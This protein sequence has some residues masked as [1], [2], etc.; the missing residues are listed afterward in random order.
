MK[1]AQERAKSREEGWDSTRD[2]T[3]IKEYNALF[4][5]N[6]RHFFE[7]PSVQAHLL[8]TGQVFGSVETQYPKHIDRNGRVIDFQKQ[9]GKLHIIEQ[10]FKQAERIE[11][12]R[13]KEERDM[14]E[15]VQKKRALALERARKEEMVLRL[16]EDRNIRQEIVRLGLAAQGG[17]SLRPE[18]SGSR[19]G[20]RTMRQ[21]RSQD[22]S[23]AAGTA[24]GTF[25]QRGQEREQGQGGGVLPREHAAAAQEEGQ[26]G[27]RR[28]SGT[29]VTEGSARP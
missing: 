6:M 17:G 11:Y 20:S 2:N 1:A 18:A 21:P 12:W 7:T 27:G 28:L 4:D 25:P 10:E 26:G 9:K 14:R 19:G 5:P 16:H 23:A 29:F 13:Q 22:G 15:R 24:R 3:R 8:R